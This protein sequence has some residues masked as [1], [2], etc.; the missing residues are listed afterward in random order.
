M[1]SPRLNYADAYKLL[2][3]FGVIFAHLPPGGRFG[4]EAWAAVQSVQELT[5]WCVLAFFAI[6]GVLLRPSLERPISVELPKRA[7][8]LL[9]PWLSFSLLYKGVVSA[10]AVAGII[11][12]TQPMPDAGRDLIA[13]LLQPADPQLYFLLYLFA[14]QT[15]L[16]LLNRCWKMLPLLMG[17]LALVFWLALVPSERR[18][19]LLYGP[20]LQLVPLYFAFLAFGLFCGTSLRRTTI[21][22]IVILPVAV[23]SAVVWAESLIAW[24]L[25]APW[26]LLLALRLFEGRAFLQPLAYLGRFSGGVYVWHAP[27]VIALVS[28]LC[29]AL[30]GAGISAVLATVLFSFVCSAA[31]GSWV[32]RTAS[33]RW[34]HI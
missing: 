21:T 15:L 23:L 31:L 6:S 12:N 8:R 10:L 28:I 7:L 19:N 16:L 34:F 14:M 24:Q 4:A 30:L 22:C 3:M 17:V 27:I 26:A 9:V 13:W 32:N 2:A 1:N 5:G 29:V 20:S 18:D 11:K 25:V 33:L